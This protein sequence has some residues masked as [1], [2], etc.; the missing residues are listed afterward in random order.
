EPHKDQG[1]DTFF[2]YLGCD[3][4]KNQAER[5]Y[6]LQAS[7]VV[8]P[9]VAV[10]GLG[11][12]VRRPKSSCGVAEGLW[13]HVEKEVRGEPRLTVV[14]PHCMEPKLQLQGTLGAGKSVALKVPVCWEI[15]RERQGERLWVR[16]IGYDDSLQPGSGW[17]VVEPEGQ[18]LPTSVP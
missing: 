15:P 3:D 8:V 13:V 7:C 10:K 4:G 14:A 1:A 18:V 2:I 12:A 5:Q 16:I 11:K 9:P 6:S 17:V